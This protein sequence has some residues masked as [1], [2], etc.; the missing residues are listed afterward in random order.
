MADLRGETNGGMVL[1][2][3]HFLKHH[4]TLA[5]VVTVW[6]SRLIALDESILNEYFFWPTLPRFIFWL[7][8]VSARKIIHGSLS[9]DLALL[10]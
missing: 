2:T 9:L 7:H 3:R 8:L 10:K 1:I 4:D 5:Q 6:L